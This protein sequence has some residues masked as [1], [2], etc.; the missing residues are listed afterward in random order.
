[1]PGV[2]A[3]PPLRAPRSLPRSPGS[4]ARA[5]PAQRVMPP[6]APRR[7]AAAEPPPPPPPREDD[8]EQDSGP[9]E[10]PLAR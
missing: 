7:A 1:M 6:K 4:F 2:R 10:L 8:P 3:R 9:E 5:G